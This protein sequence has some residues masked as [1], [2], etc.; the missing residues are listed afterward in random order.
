MT[1]TNTYKR[2]YIK[3]KISE[4]NKKTKT[5]AKLL[6]KLNK[7]VAIQLKAIKLL[8]LLLLLLL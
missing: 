8:L 2:Q 1:A 7:T 4:K 5:N 3:R 6:S